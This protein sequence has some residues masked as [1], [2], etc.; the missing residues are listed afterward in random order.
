M[1]NTGHAEETP[2]LGE[3]SYC[4]TCGAVYRT[5]ASCPNGH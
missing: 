1:N 3:S 2:S 4:G 5:G